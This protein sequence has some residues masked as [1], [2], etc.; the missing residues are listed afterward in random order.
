[1]I[2]KE[3]LKIIN[4]GY[5]LEVPYRMVWFREENHTGTISTEIVS[6]NNNTVVVKATVSNSENK[7]LGTGLAMKMAGSDPISAQFVECAET[8]ARGRALAAAGYGTLDA[9]IKLGI[10]PS[11]A[12]QVADDGFVPEVVEAPIPAPVS[13]P[14]NPAFTAE[15]KVIDNSAFDKYRETA[16]KAGGLI[17]LE[18]EISLEEA[19]KYIIEATTRKGMTME[20]Y[21][22]SVP[23]SM[24]AKLCDPK[25]AKKYG[26]SPICSVCCRIVKA[27]MAS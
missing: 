10:N 13:A 12:A 2:E 19:R 18:S 27:A 22:N 16:E 3:N 26:L 11:E 14:A 9:I 15:N 6:V 23:D 1:M 4:G 20:E 17:Q 5:Y 21:I 8:A 7:V 24:S 25:T